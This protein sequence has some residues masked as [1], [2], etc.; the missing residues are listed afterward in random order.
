MKERGDKSA[1]KFD[2]LVSEGEGK[3]MSEDEKMALAAQKMEEKFK[4]EGTSKKGKVGSNRESVT[5]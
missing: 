1:K 2:E 3:G 5:L 4:E